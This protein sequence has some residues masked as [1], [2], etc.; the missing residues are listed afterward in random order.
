MPNGLIHRGRPAAERARRAKK[1]KRARSRSRATSRCKKG[2]LLIKRKGYYR[3]DGTY[4]KPTT[5]CIK[6]QGTPGRRARG[7][8]GGP[9]AKEKPWITRE[10]KLGGEGYLKKSAAERRKLL[11]KC[12]RNYG[13]RSCLGSVMVL[14]R[15][16]AIRAKYGNKITVDREYL[17]KKYGGPGSFGKGARSRSASPK[18]KQKRAKK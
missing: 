2:E 5:Y 10:G 17:K 18:R 12:V 13:Y 8:K 16:T 6:D 15:N 11:D 1:A 14:N 3:K 4:V 7:A 9:Y